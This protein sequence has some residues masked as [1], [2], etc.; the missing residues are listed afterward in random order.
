MQRPIGRGMGFFTLIWF[1]QL[2]SILGSGLSGFAVGISVFQETGLVTRY[3]L[4]GLAMSLPVIL[5]SPLAGVL[6][7][8]FDRRLILVFSIFGSAAGTLILYWLVARGLLT[9]W[10]LYPIL[11]LKAA[12]GAFV[13]PTFSAAT[14]LIVGREHLGR[15]SGMNQ[16]GA[17][18]SQIFAPLLGGLLVG[19]I[20]VGGVILIDIATFFV[21]AFILLTIRFPQPR[22]DAAPADPAPAD[23]VPTDA[24]PTDRA[25]AD[26]GFRVGW[27]F[28]RE[29][30][31]LLCLLLLF[32]ALNLCTGMVEVLIAPLVLSFASARTLGVVLS[33]A[34]AGGLVGGILMSVWGGPRPR[35]RVVAILT[36]ALVEGVLMMIGGL[37]P[38]ATLITAAA[39]FFMLGFPVTA[40]SIQA[41]WQTKT[42]P[43]IQGRVFAIRRM[44]AG[45]AF[46]MA[47]A[48]AG[49]L[50]DRVF[51]PLLAAGGPLSVGVVGRVLGVGPGRGV[52]LLLVVSGVLVMAIVGLGFRLSVLRRLEVDVPDAAGVPR[53]AETAAEK[54]DSGIGRVGLAPALALAVFVVLVTAAVLRLERPPSIAEEPPADGFSVARAFRHLETISARPHPTGSPAQSEVRDYLVARL[55]GL[56]LETE[57]QHAH[58]VSSEPS[59]IRVVTVDNVV[60]RLAGREKDR[61]AGRERGRA[62]LFAAHYDSVVT[63]P[64]ASDNGAAVAALL[65]TARVMAAAP[66]PRNDVIFFFPDA[67]EPG[68][69]GARAFIARHPWARDVAVVVNFDARGRGGP[70]YMFQTGSDNGWWIP[71][72]IAGAPRPRASS[73]L[74][75][76]YRRLPNDTDFT[77]FLEAGYTGF[78]LA[79]I[80]GLTHY[81]TMLDRPQDLD[82]RS[83]RHQGS[84][85]LGLARHFAEL[86]LGAASGQAR[87]KPD[88]AYFNVLGSAMVHYPRALAA[89]SAVLAAVLY[90]AVLVTGLRRRRLS[91]FGLWQGVLAFLG[92][93]VAIP[94]AVTLVW[95][96]IRDA[97]QVT[98]LMGSTE[99]AWLFMLAFASLTLA[100]FAMLQ[101]FFRG[102]VGA[103]NLA[104]GALAWW[105]IAALLASG[106]WLPVESNYLFVWPL[107]GSLLGVGYLCRSPAGALRPWRTAA[108]LAGACVP[109]LLLAVPFCAVM[110]VGLQSVF[111]LGGAALSVQV[112]L[113]GLLTPLIEIWTARRARWLAAA[114]A[115]AGAAFLAAALGSPAE[116]RGVRVDSVIYT[117]DADTDESHW[118]SLDDGPDEW[119]RQFGFERGVTGPFTHFFP[120]T[121]REFLKSS[122]PA[123]EVPRPEM[124]VVEQRPLGEK[125]RE[126]RIRLR[127]TAPS[128]V[129]AIWFEPA[130]AVVTV[131]MN[132]RSFSPRNAEADGAPPV[133]QDIPAAREE[134][135]TLR[136]RGSEPVRIHV[137]DQYEGLPDLP[138]LAPR[139]EGL[140]PRPLQF[141]VRSDVTLVRRSFVLAPTSILPEAF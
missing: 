22:P 128:P 20:G 11:A 66:A 60:A 105:L 26:R 51:E 70:V 101:R 24:A 58:E 117:L 139:P 106:P 5:L 41:I 95:F 137:T 1:G 33:I 115:L 7:D 64:G 23:P 122:A 59:L 53:V 78:N 85:A 40:G 48:L 31:G 123:A 108:V 140:L 38:N 83:L 98:V 79:F 88:R 73:L 110:Y 127:T 4:I 62:V 63:A 74:N 77:A 107:V 86:D 135:M 109:G 124:E 25:P 119:T 50:A 134:E 111:E 91:A 93:A 130:E 112:L 17:A 82:P 35:Q 103:L 97:A 14:T 75:Q 71:R 118:F 29:R 52:A 30:P 42:P 55:R 102:V 36:I 131:V 120:L 28:V 32:A 15:A 57:V 65:E 37:R 99:G 94:V 43:E 92:M 68:L 67:E 8:R 141:T 136:V 39:F 76:I 47:F 16:M 89:V 100:A 12:A 19:P 87:Q 45:S 113:L 3:A 132:G 18:V 138:S 104:M 9:S 81:H 114:A 21:S 80:E 2:V 44:I 69:H 54:V 116:L 10:H 96:V 61:L 49:P 27:N 13:W 126:Y 84:Y 90:V 6:A 125:F 72:F 46:P 133:I 121:P 129:R 34:A 56:G